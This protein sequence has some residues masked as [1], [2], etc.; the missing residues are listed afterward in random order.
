MSELNVN[1]ENKYDFEGKNDNEIEQDFEEKNNSETGHDFEKI[2][3]AMLF[4]TGEGVE[5]ARLAE[6]LGIE[7]PAVRGLLAEMAERREK[8]GS[9]ILLLEVGDSYQL[10]TNP[11]Y[12]E[13]AIRLLPGSP[14]RTLTQPLLETLSIIAYKQPVTKAVIEEIRGVSA[15][16]AVSRLMEYGLVDE[17]GRLDAPGR[18]IL[19]CTSED[20][21]RYFGLKSVEEFLLLTGNDSII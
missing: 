5:V 11:K 7:I 20:F 21:L 2:L 14:R 19:F 13:H 1:Y 6:A 17:C 12:Y 18:P 16:H 10:C 15:E 3:E 8:E 9:G 4:A